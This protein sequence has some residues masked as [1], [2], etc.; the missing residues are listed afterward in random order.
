[1]LL[2]LSSSPPI[3][4]AWSRSDKIA[5]L[6]IAVCI[7]LFLL[8][9]PLTRSTVSYK[10]KIVAVYD[11]RGV[12]ALTVKNRGK[13]SAAVGPPKLVFR[14]SRAARLIWMIFKRQKCQDI[15]LDEEAF[16][17]SSTQLEANAKS[18]WFLLPDAERKYLLP[19]VRKPFAPFRIRK[20]SGRE[21]FIRVSRGAKGSKYVRTTK[22]TRGQHPYQDIPKE[23]QREIEH[24][25]AARTEHSGSS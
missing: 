5:L 17:S 3:D 21:T 6:A 12:L 16:P 11:S 14:R 9:V 4:T 1:M 20:P 24:R 22:I 18:L 15:L 2:Q 25:I 7:V 8:G 10:L 19:Q 13:Q 23:F